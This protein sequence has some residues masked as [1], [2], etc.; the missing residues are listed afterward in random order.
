[1]AHQTALEALH[2]FLAS[3]FELPDAAWWLV[4]L[5]KKKALAVLVQAL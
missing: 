1:M 2:A 5:L 4:N 3:G